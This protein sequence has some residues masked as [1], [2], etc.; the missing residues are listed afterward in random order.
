M[1]AA[2]P[3]HGLQRPDTQPGWRRVGWLATERRE[4]ATISKRL[5]EWERGSLRGR[6][7]GEPKSM[8]EQG[9]PGRGCA[10]MPSGPQSSV[11]RRQTYTAFPFANLRRRRCSSRLGHMAPVIRASA[12]ALLPVIAWRELGLNR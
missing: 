8:S 11:N 10:G 5:I 3:V 2:V 1:R 4:G 9:D 7:G 12:D 6:R